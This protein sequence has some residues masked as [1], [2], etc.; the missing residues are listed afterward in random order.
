MAVYVA[1][2]AT[3][4]KHWS[5]TQSTVA[6]SSDEA[7]LVGICK[8]A[9][10]SMGLRAL[11]SDLGLEPKIRVHTDAAAAIGMARRRG[12]GKVR[13][14]ATSDMWIQDRI[15]SRDFRLHKVL[16]AENPSDILTKAIDRASLCK[17]LA[18]SNLGFEEGRADSASQIV[19]AQAS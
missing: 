4:L 15:A 5:V 13:H 3:V 2:V 1:W 17:H 11:C 18:R 8:G 12:L 16:G 14:L 19:D 7:E 6:L 9:S 10:V